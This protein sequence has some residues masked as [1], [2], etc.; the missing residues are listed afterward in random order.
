M[1]QK[2]RQP[3]K[4]QSDNSAVMLL[5]SRQWLLPVSKQSALL[6][7]LYC[8]VLIVFSKPFALGLYC[9]VSTVLSKPI[10]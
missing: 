9:V 4:K 5:Q 6:I 8:L 2:A 1:L 10:V 3:K 7:D